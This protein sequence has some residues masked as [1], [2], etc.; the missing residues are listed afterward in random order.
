MDLND[1]PELA[2]YRTRVRSW[3]SEHA[4]EALARASKNLAKTLPGRKSDSPESESAENDAMA[5]SEESSDDAAQQASD[6]SSGK[7]QAS[8]GRNGEGGTE[9]PKDKAVVAGDGSQLGR[10]KSVEELG[11]SASDWARLGPLMQQDLLNAAQQTGPP[12]YR[13]MI[14]NYYIRIARVQSE[15]AE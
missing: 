4:A 15:E 1:T 3:L 14:K 8:D 12:A 9:A 2:E 6:N 10:P 7:Q 13:E 11:I 5:S